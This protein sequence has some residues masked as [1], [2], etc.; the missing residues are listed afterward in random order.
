M[1][2]R[3]IAPIAALLLAISGL[4]FGTD[5]TMRPPPS[6]EHKTLKKNRSSQPPSI[7][8]RGGTSNWPYGPGYNFPYPDRPYGDPGHG[9]E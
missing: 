6:K 1:L 9:G 7:D 5:Q 2:T 3:Q 4:S 8:Y